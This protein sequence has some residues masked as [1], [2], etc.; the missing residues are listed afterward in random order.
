MHMIEAKFVSMPA[1]EL[2]LQNEEQSVNRSKQSA[3]KYLFSLEENRVHK[4]LHVHN[5]DSGLCG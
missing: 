4:H 5:I 3:K 1:T 2:A